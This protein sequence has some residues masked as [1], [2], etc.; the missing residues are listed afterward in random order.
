M[1]VSAALWY[2]MAGEDRLVAVLVECLQRD[3]GSDEDTA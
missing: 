2:T 3:C 1:F